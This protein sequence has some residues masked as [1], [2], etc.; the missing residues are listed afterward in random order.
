MKR[1]LLALTA[2]VVLLLTT[3]VPALA[4]E[5]RVPV[6][7]PELEFDGTTAECAV[8]ITSPGEEINA[9]LSLWNGNTYIDSWSG[10]GTTLV[11][12]KGNCPVIKGQTYTLKVTGTAGSET[13]TGPTVSGTC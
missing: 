8:T 4:V 9:T 12:I 2:V 7:A 11:R 5:P 1:R 3:S 6:A 13:F 10:S